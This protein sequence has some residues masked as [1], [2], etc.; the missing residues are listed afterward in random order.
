MRRVT[1]QGA[2]RAAHCSGTRCRTWGYY[3][4]LPPDRFPN[5][6]SLADVLTS[7]DGDDRFEFGLEM[8]VYGI[9][10]YVGRH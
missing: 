10:S 5:L 3:L 7:G 1:E 8:L 6:T 4:S 2:R 9:A